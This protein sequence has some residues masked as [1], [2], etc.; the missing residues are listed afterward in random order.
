MLPPSGEFRNRPAVLA[1][2]LGPGSWKL[3]SSSMEALKLTSVPSSDHLCFGSPQ[4]AALPSLEVP[5]YPE[6][7]PYGFFGS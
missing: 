2:V 7:N 4:S 3:V 6:P 1:G 5:R